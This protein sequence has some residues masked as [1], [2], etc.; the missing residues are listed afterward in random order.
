[1]IRLILIASLGACVS[2]PPEDYETVMS[3]VADKVAMERVGELRESLESG[4]Y[5]P[6]PPIPAPED[7]DPLDYV[8]GGGAMA[9]AVSLLRRML[10]IDPVP[11]IADMLTFKK[12]RDARKKKDVA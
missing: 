7:L 8:L 6:A 3:H 2:A 4:V 11:L 1:M 9:F 10:P 12:A 5:N